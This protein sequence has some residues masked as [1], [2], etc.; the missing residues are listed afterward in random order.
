MPETVWFL[1]E[2]WPGAIAL[3][4]SSK[5]LDLTDATVERLELLRGGRIRRAEVQILRGLAGEVAVPRP[6]KKRTEYQFKITYLD[7]VVV[8]TEPIIIMVLPNA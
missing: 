5:P 6:R 3:R 2:N 4:D 7:G 8:F 1:K